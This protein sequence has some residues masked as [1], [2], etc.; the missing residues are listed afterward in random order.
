MT[1]YLTLQKVIEMGSFTRAAEQLGYTQSA[2]SQMIASLEKD[3]GMKLLTRSHSGVALTIEGKELYPYIERIIYQYRSMREKVSEIRGLDTGSIRIGTI[4]S[5]SYQWLPDLV[6]GFQA[7]YPNVQFGFY[8]GDYSAVEGWVKTGAVD[9]GFVTPP[10][11]TGLKIQPL[12]QGEMVL[13]FPA[14]HPFAQRSSVRLEEIADEPFILLEE[15]SYNEA[16]LAF[17]RAK[18]KPNIKYAIHDDFT[19]MKMVQNGMGIS[20]LSRLILRDAKY[21]IIPVSLDPPVY[22]TLA[23][24]YK[25][26]SSLPIAAKLFLSYLYE[27]R[28]TL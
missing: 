22:R 23:I 5:V 1:R 10:A 12:V 17:E 6:R 15:G 11:V 18:V 8:Q 28:S 26:K 7:L 27:N 9:F 2:V 3:L 21:R 25:D 19:I 4:S 16:L 20:I 24:G 14:E 13:I